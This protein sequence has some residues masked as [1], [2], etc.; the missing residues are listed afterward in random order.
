MKLT[1]KLLSVF[2]GILVIAFAIQDC[3]DEKTSE[4]ILENYVLQDH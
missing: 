3:L 2:L 4:H 1:F